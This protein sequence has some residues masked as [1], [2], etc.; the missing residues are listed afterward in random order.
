MGRGTRNARWFVS[1]F[2]FVFIDSLKGTSS[3]DQFA[4]A[5]QH[6]FPRNE[7][8]TLTTNV[9]SSQTSSLRYGAR[10]QLVVLESSANKRVD[11]FCFDVIN[12][13]SPPPLFLFPAAIHISEKYLFL[14]IYERKSTSLRVVNPFFFSF[15]FCFVVPAVNPIFFHSNSMIRVPSSY[16]R[17]YAPL[18]TGSRDPVEFR[19]QMSSFAYFAPVP[20]MQI[21]FFPPPCWKLARRRPRIQPSFP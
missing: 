5:S 16:P 12:L 20:L 18:T 2:F 1:L 21:I 19:T 14:H 6:A 13:S 9:K 4:V 7:T 3:S 10:S 17:R 11:S 8:V 15:L